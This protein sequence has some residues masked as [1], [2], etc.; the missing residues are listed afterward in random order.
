MEDISPS[1]GNYHVVA[2]SK[3]VSEWVLLCRHALRNAL[4]PLV[5]RLG[6]SLAGVVGGALIIETIFSWEGMGLLVVEASRAW[7]YPLMQGTFI[8]AVSPP[9]IFNTV[10]MA[11]GAIL[12]EAG[13]RFLGFVLTGYAL[14]EILNPHIRKK[15]I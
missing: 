9:V 1:R 13:L 5:T 10:M 8:P 14:K 11:G 7:D 12:A 3:G 2:R 6:L 4:L 15:R